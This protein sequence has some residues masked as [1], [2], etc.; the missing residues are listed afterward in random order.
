MHLERARQ[1]KSTYIGRSPAG[2]A[3]QVARLEEAECV[4][5]SEAKGSDYSYQ[6]YIYCIREE[7]EKIGRTRWKGPLFTTMQSASPTNSLPTDVF[8]PVNT[9][10]ILV[11]N[12]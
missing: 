2:E 11:Y 7:R 3:S 9:S 12:S 8:L 4:F 10:S 1:V 6:A 5:I